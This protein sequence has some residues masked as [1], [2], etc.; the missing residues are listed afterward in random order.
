[1]KKVREFM[2]GKVITV[3]PSTPVGELAKL[4]LDTG[5]S[6]FPVVDEDNGLVGVVS[7]RDLIHR[8]QKLHIPTFFTIFDSVFSFGANKKLEEE[9][10]VVAA[11]T[12]RDIMRE[13]VTV[14][15]DATHSDV[16]TLMGDTG[17]YTLPV[18]DDEGE[19]VG[20]VGK[21]DIIKAM[22]DAI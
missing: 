21:R 8:D 7:E 6:G 4:F 10:K 12:V 3:T 20:I 15:P 14:S 17:A 11:S 22:G 19:I 1:M 13:A 9:M 16:A 5:V 2:T 18:L